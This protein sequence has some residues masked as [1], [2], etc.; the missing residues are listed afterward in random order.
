MAFDYQDLDPEVL[1]AIMGPPTPNAATMGIDAGQIAG[2][3]P[4]PQGMP[5][6]AVSGLDAGAQASQQLPS[7]MPF[8]PGPKTA[9]VGNIDPV[10]QQ[11]IAKQYGFGPGLD[12][13]AIKAAQE[14]SRGDMLSANLGEAGNDIASAFAAGR[15]STKGPDNKFYQ[16]LREQAQQPL[17]NI[18]QMRQA[19]LGDMQAGNAFASN[20]PN[21]SVSKAV[22]NAYIKLGFP[23]GSLRSLAANDLKEIQSPAELS[24]KLQNQKDMK[25]LGLA[26]IKATK[27][28]AMG[29][30]Q[31][32]KIAG[33]Y[34]DTMNDKVVSQAKGQL[35][36]ADE[37]MS[38][39]ND[40]TS[41]PVSANALSA[42]AA[43]YVSGGQ[44]INR[45]E[46][47][48]LG[49]G[50][51]DI[52]DKLNQIMQTGSKGTLTPE[53]AAFMRKFV[54]VTRK[55]AEESFQ[56]A[57]KD[58]AD[59]YAKIYGLNS[60]DLYDKFG[61]NSRIS[62][63]SDTKGTAAGMHPPGSTVTVKGKAYRVAADGDNLEPMGDSYAA[64]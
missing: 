21:S 56:K 28:L 22:Q 33:A 7:P 6:G 43:R 41:N 57:V 16:G 25:E 1:K 8:H 2:T 45:Q 37:L 34:K 47:E 52:S 53:N 18:N 62:G 26:N 64:Q 58:R 5:S 39:T 29:S 3:S 12:S 30:K 50:A 55:T 36:Q 51:K 4:R 54:D 20:D 63:T 17:Q 49:G 19:K 13:D 40:A 42:L 23:E 48:A 9:S 46:M 60:Q 31:T 11:A 14:K 35:A 27:D 10:V 61:V 59:S 15:G 44:R 38:A 32:D 24:A